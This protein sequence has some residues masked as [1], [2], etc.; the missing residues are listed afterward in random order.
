MEVSFPAVIE[1]DASGGYSVFFPDLP[2]CVSAGDSIEDAFAMAREALA[3]HLEVMAEYGDPIP[4]AT[5]YGKVKVPRGVKA[6]AVVLVPVV[7]PGKT[8]RLNVTLDS[9]LVARI[10]SLTDNRSA[11]LSAAAREALARH[12]SG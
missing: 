4:A 5:P 9:G 2:G 3:G 11:W 6:V 10:D 7:L 12:K 1:T 8:V